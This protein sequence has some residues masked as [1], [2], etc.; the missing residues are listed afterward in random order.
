MDRIDKKILQLLQENGRMSNQE[1]AEKVAL[2]PSPCLRRVKQLEENGYIK[3][4]TALLDPQTV[5]LELTVLVSVTLVSHNPKTMAAFEKAIQAIPAVIHCY[6]VAGQ[7]HEYML[8][9]VAPTLN[10]YQELLLQQL[11]QIDSV[12]N[13]NSSF[14]MRNVIDNPALPLDHLE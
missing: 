12:K 10:D 13:V 7:A 14:V 9:V 11:I 2:S 1:L 8:T 6:L 5:G 3:H 4:Y